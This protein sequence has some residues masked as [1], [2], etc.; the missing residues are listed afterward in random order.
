MN[1]CAGG[2]GVT[3]TYPPILSADDDAANQVGYVLETLS[4]YLLETAYGFYSH[5]I[6]FQIDRAARQ[7]ALL[8]LASHIRPMPVS[9]TARASDQGASI[10]VQAASLLS[11][12]GFLAYTPSLGPACRKAII[13][14]APT[15]KATSTLLDSELVPSRARR[16]AAYMRARLAACA[17]LHQ[18]EALENGSKP[19]QV[20]QALAALASDPWPRVAAELV[21][22]GV[23]DE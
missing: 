4:D 2:T 18:E 15:D 20:L 13:A 22:N 3:G 19:S 16:E 11:P 7:L 6:S 17:G 21:G 9:V 5:S 23:V 10:M 12:D 8:V 14:S 1:P